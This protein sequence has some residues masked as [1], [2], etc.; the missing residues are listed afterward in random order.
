[1]RCAIP[2][3]AQRK[4]HRCGAQYPG[5][6]S[7]PGPCM[8]TGLPSTRGRTDAGAGSCRAA[9]P[10]GTAHGARGRSGP[11]PVGGRGGAGGPPGAA[12]RPGRRRRGCSRRPGGVPR[13]DARGVAGPGPAGV[14]GHPA[15]AVRPSATGT[16]GRDGGGG[17]G[18]GGVCLLPAESPSASNFGT[19]PRATGEIPQLSDRCGA[20]GRTRPAK[21]TTT[22]RTSEATKT[23]SS[24]CL[25]P[26]ESPSAS[27]RPT[28]GRG[29][30]LWRPSLYGRSDN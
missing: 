28:R 1:M 18:G 29:R 19:E 25:L 30:T 2:S 16:R 3:A 8:V 22:T 7:P 26:A 6:T 23:D 14:G 12:A 11:G 17:G 9:P 15:G 27:G 10:A 5:L 20:D 13:P 4:W 21:V 24:G